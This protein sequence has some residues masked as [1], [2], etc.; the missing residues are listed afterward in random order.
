M[1]IKNME[2]DK[3]AKVIHDELN[4]LGIYTIGELAQTSKSFLEKHFK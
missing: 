1:I 2:R 4:K 3:Y